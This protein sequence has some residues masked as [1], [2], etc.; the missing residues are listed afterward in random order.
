[1][2]MAVRLAVACVLI[3]CA[4]LTAGCAGSPDFKVGDCVKIRQRLTD[5]T[6]DRAAC[7]SNGGID[8]DTG[9]IS[10]EETTYRV[11]EVINGTDGHCSFLRTEATVRFTDEPD[12]A[13]Y[14]L[15]P[16]Y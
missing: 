7:R 6:L 9:F 10:E 13:V 12:N 5:H 2:I 15:S 8:P 14:C 3:G 1:M 4:S 11:T 16:L